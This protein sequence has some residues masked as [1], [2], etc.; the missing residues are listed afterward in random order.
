MVEEVLPKDLISRV[1]SRQGVTRD[2]GV[3]TQIVT[4]TGSRVSKSRQTLGQNKGDDNPDRRG[5]TVLGSDW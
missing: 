3:G 4:G 1:D 5:V 2:S